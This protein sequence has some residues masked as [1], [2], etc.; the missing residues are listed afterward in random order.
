MPHDPRWVRLFQKQ[1]KILKD[2]FG[3]T[4]LAIEHV[5]STAIPGMPAK[6]IIDIDVGVRSMRDIVAMRKK[7]K[8]LGY[9]HRPFVP[10][11]TKGELKKQELF[12]VGSGAKRTHHIHIAI[13]GSNYWNNN[14]LFRDYLRAHP[15]RAKKYAALKCQLVKKFANDRNRYTKAKEKFISATIQLAQK[16]HPKRVETP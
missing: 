11:V 16:R 8:A 3:D 9:Q 10:G 5:G 14:I 15:A 1:K 13:F 2:T 7:F 4:I 6:P 12:V